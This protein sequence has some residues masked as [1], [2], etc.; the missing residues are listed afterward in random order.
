MVDVISD[1][2]FKVSSVIKR[3]MSD[4]DDDVTTVLVAGVRIDFVT[5]VVDTTMLEKDVS[6][7]IVV[8]ILG[9]W[10]S[11]TPARMSCSFQWGGC[12]KRGFQP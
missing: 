7:A 10:A 1:D 12:R 2:G 8:K 5:L 9:I 4:N 3:K 11:M 6:V